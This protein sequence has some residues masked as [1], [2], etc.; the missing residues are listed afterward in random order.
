MNGAPSLDVF[1]SLNQ[2]IDS[3]IDQRY[4]YQLKYSLDL[5]SY[6]IA[7]GIPVTLTRVKC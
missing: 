1:Q 7:S 3:H 4:I 2:G 5:L 6:S